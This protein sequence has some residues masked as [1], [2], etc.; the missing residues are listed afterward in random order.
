[1]GAIQQQAITWAS[2]DPDLC[3]HM[4]DMASQGHIDFTQRSFIEL[5]LLNQWSWDWDQY[6]KI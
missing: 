6:T 4:Y 1:M 2:V 5:T 3:H